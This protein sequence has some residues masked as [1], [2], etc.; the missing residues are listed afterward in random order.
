ML[1]EK[2]MLKL[3]WICGCGSENFT[4]E[5]WVAHWKYGVFKE[6]TFFG[7]HPKLRAIKHL[8]FTRIVLA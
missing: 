6:D 5:D 4:W 1:G 2:V 3:K 7:R 8:L